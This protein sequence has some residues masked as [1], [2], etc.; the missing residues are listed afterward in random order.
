MEPHTTADRSPPPEAHLKPTAARPGRGGSCVGTSWLGTT[1]GFE[2]AVLTARGGA[3]SG[4][5]ARSHATVL[6][7][8][9]QDSSA[10][11]L[12]ARMVARSL[13]SILLRKSLVGFAPFVAYRAG[14]GAAGEPPGLAQ[15]DQP[16]TYR[17]F[18]QRFVWTGLLEPATDGGRR[19]AASARATG[20]WADDPTPARKLGGGATSHAQPWHAHA[21]CDP[22]PSRRPVKARRPSWRPPTPH[23]RPLLYHGDP[24]SAGRDRPAGR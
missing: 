2:D 19:T 14:S 3:S 6:E 20:P 8:P 21:S 16:L 5:T 24:Q 18:A 22:H 17:E 11:A 15:L 23:D 4:V 12:A 10:R 1:E 13:A 9:G 7:P